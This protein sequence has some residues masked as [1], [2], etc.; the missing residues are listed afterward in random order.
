MTDEQIFVGKIRLLALEK[1]QHEC[2]AE[3]AKAD[4][5]ELELEAT[6]KAVKSLDDG[7]KAIS[8]PEIPGSN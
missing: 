3:K 2:R 7:L 1:A 5:A 8:L 6:R 4:R